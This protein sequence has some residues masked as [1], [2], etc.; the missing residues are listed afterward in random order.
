VQ[1]VRNSSQEVAALG[2]RV[3]AIALGP[4]DN[5]PDEYAKWT[6]RTIPVARMGRPD[7]A[8]AAVVDLASEEAGRA[9]GQL[10]AVNGGMNPS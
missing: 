3:N 1:L 2:V 5:L 10:L 4:M 7:D 8:G 6:V 9:T